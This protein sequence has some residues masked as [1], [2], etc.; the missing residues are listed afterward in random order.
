MFVKEKTMYFHENYL[1]ISVPDW[2]SWLFV[3]IILCLLFIPLLSKLLYK[4]RKCNIT[5]I[6]LRETQK[7]I[8]D[9]YLLSPWRYN[10]T[11][12]ISNFTVDVYYFNK[13]NIVTLNCS[14]DIFNKLIVGK[15]Y[16]ARIK[17]NTIVS[18]KLCY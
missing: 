3:L 11:S 17:F 16:N 9:I 5:I 2:F 8:Y 7:D 14:Y 13:K 6:K 12:T 18:A 10:S 15:T 1:T 4:G